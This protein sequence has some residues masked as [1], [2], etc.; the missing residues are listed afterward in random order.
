[1]CMFLLERKN[2]CTVIFEDVRYLLQDW[3]GFVVK[4]DALDLIKMQGMM[5]TKVLKVDMGTLSFTDV[6]SSA[7]SSIY[8]V[9]EMNLMN[10]VK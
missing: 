1:M 9:N 3:D 2:D 7:M 5:A 10:V 4:E 8:V 6:A